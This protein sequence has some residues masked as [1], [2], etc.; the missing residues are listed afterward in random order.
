M[1][2]QRSW[3]LVK[4]FFAGGK[5]SLPQVTSTILLLSVALMLALVL[6]PRFSQAPADRHT[7]H[8]SRV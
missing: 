4:V 3:N 5:M 7:A 1:F 6:P 2:F 8:H